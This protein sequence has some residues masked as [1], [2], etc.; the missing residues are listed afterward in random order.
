MAWSNN[1]SKGSNQRAEVRNEVVDLLLWCFEQTV[2][3]DYVRLSCKLPSKAPQGSGND[4]RGQGIRVSVMA[5]ISNPTDKSPLTQIEEG[6]Y[7]K[8]WIH[9]HGRL[10]AE[11]WID[12]NKQTQTDLTVW[13][14]KVHK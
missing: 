2:K 9:V 5:R 11:D 3:G 6:D 7:S 4:A 14:T 13:A 12:K 10:Q 8:G 1:A